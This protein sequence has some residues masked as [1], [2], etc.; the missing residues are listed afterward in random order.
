M[1]AVGDSP[2]WFNAVNEQIQAQI[3]MTDAASGR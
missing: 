2:A 3:G 1:L